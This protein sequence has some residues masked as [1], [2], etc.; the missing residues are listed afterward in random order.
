MHTISSQTHQGA[1]VLHRCQYIDGDGM[2]CTFYLND[3][4]LSYHCPLHSPRFR[5]LAN[6]TLFKRPLTWSKRRTIMYTTQLYLDP[7]ARL[8]RGTLHP[9]AA[10]RL[11][12]APHY[13]WVQIEIVH[14]ERLPAHT[15]G[16]VKQSTVR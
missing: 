14:A 16:W 2:Q 6:L 4:D 11:L 9:G 12:S 5:L 15:R 1:A 8:S 7:Q 13:G 10:I 3:N